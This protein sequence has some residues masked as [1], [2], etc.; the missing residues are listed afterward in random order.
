[1]KTSQSTL[2]SHFGMKK[3]EKIWDREKYPRYMKIW[4]DLYSDDLTKSFTLEFQKKFKF[5][6]FKEIF[7]SKES[8]D[9]KK[10]LAITKELR[11]RKE[12]YDKQHWGH[13]LHSLS[14]YQGRLTPSFVYWLIRAFSSPDM[15][16]LDPFCGAG[17]V[18]LEADF[19]GRHGIGNDLNPY[20]FLIA[21]G[22]FDRRPLNAHLTYLKNI[23]ND[24]V[25]NNESLDEIPE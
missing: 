16:I 1:M 13:W 5:E 20:A 4:R 2:L 7:P 6:K 15:T 9:I 18:P 25:F 17:T 22:K 19:L 8:F 11:W 21:K 12:P 24:V 10:A 23:S 3:K 14:P